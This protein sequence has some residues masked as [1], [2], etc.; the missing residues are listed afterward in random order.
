MTDV[1]SHV[2]SNDYRHPTRCLGKPPRSPWTENAESRVQLELATFEKLV[3]IGD[4]G[5]IISHLL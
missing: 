3:S 1:I 4:F 2:V 5:L